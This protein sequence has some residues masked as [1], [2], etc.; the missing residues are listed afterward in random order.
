MNW[1]KDDL[2]LSDGSIV[3]AQYPQIIS[4]S[5]S[6]DIPAFYADWFFNRLKEGYCA[7]TNPFNGVKSYVAFR[8]T[9]FIVFWSKNPEPLLS[10]LD[11][12]KERSI[13]CYIQYTLNDYV[14]EGLEKGVPALDKR[15]DTFKRLVD[16]LGKGHVIWRF[17]PLMLTDDVNEEFLLEKISNIAVQ[18]KGYTEKLVFSFADILSYK[19]V[20]RNLDDHNVH[21]IEWQPDQMMDFAR[22]LADA[23]KEWGFTLATC[24]EKIDLNDFGIEHNK[25][26]DDDLMIK[27][28]WRDKALMDFLGLE[29]YQKNLFGVIPK[30][31]IL[32]SYNLYATKKRNN[33]DTGQRLFCGC[34]NSKDIGQYNTCPHQCEYCYANTTKALAL[35]NYKMHLLHPDAETIT[36]D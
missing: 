26:I 17:D 36:G 9:R 18:L 12:L 31:A 19:K 8:D 20:K 22:R 7:W 11:E 29:I 30:G 1:K 28:A 14:N 27:L 25:C 3:K 16:K 6:T 10:H 4:A 32:L 34:A 33:K 2:K 35:R 23:N 24:A 21:Y 15:I 13:G 5:R